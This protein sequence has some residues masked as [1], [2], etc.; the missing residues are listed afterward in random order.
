VRQPPLPL[1]HTGAV[2]GQQAPLPQS[3]PQSPHPGSPGGQHSTCAG[4]QLRHVRFALSQTGAVVGQHPPLPQSTPQTPHPGSPGGQHSTSDGGQAG[5]VV[6]VVVDVD[7]VVVVLLL[8]VG[9]ATS[10]PTTSSAI[11]SGDSGVTS[12]NCSLQLN[13]FCTYGVAWGHGPL[14]QSPESP[15]GS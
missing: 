12:A 10:Q 15:F 13:A 5:A 9:L 8:A 4:P 11:P 1:S 7:G 3:V 2:D 14:S 6:V